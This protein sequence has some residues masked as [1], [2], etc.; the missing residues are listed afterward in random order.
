MIVISDFDNT[1]YPHFDDELFRQNLE[2]VKKFRQA[3]DLFCLASGRNIL[4]LE[5]TWPEYNDYLDYIILENGAVCL[6]SK[7][8]VLFQYAIEQNLAVKICQDIQSTFAGQTTFAY[9]H[10][11][12]EWQTLDNDVTKI[13]C[14]ATDGATGS[15]ILRDL[16]GK[17]GNHIQIFLDPNAI[18][19]RVDWIHDKE[20]YHAFVDIVSTQ[21]GK[22]NAVRRLSQ[23]LSD[24]NI[25]TIGDDLNDLGMLKQYNGYAM[26]NSTPE[27]LESIS[28]THTI[29]SVAELLYRLLGQKS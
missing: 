24:D 21:A 18:A 15:Q 14:W 3:G 1:L 7:R 28:P 17:Y 4:S 29:D 2:A 13:R 11:G 16:T 6:D 26:K 5:R 8:D 12:K 27:V 9:Y 20:Q 19:T 23:M 25:I 10:S 22:E